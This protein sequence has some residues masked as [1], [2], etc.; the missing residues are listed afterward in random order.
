MDYIGDLIVEAFDDPNKDSW[1]NR[2]PHL[3]IVLTIFIY[4]V[5][6]II[7]SYLVLNS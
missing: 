7:I 3:T 6:Q 2:H 4:P 1:F 5:S